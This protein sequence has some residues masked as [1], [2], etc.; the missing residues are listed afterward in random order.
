MNAV[1]DKEICENTPTFDLETE[2]VTY[3][4]MAKRILNAELGIDF[5][6]D[7]IDDRINNRIKTV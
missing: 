2:S 6:T 1:K 3:V 5:I 4:S 7:S